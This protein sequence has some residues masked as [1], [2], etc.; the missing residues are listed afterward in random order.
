MEETLFFALIGGIA[1]SFLNVVIYRL[2][3]ILAGES[4]TLCWPASHCPICKNNIRFYH[5]IP[6]L[7]WLWL[8]GRC[9]RCHSPIPVRYFLVE[10]IMAILFPT[11]I[12]LCGMSW[13]SLVDLIVLSCL[14]PLF[15][16]D[17]T[18]LLLPDRLTFTVM[19]SS[20]VLAGLG[21]GG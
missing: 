6:L 17:L 16:I 10:L 18:C 1:G 3:R 4:L 15:I 14:L 12:S 9:I 21:R 13:Q 20:L 19:L 11:M 7:G 8:R 5:N 2:P